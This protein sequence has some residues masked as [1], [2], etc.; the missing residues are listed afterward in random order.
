[1]PVTAV[2]LE[3]TPLEAENGAALRKAGVDLHIGSFAEER[4]MRPA[5]EGADTVHHI[6]AAMREAN[7]PDSH[8]YEINCEATKRL[9][10]WSHE[11]GVRRF[12]YCSTSGV[13][14][15]SHGRVTDE[16][17]ECRPKDIY[18]KSKWAAEQAVFAFGQETGMEVTA[19]RPAAAY[20]AGDGRLLKL[21]RMIQKGRFPLVG[22]GRGKHHL[23]YIDDLN[24]AMMMVAERQEAVGRVYNVAGAESV[25]LVDLVQILAEELGT[26]CTLQ[27]IPMPAMQLLATV[28][29]FSCR[30]FGIQPPLYRRRLDFYRHDEHFSIERAETELGFEPRISL[31][32]G[33]RLTI[34]GYRKQ[35]WL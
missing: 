16:N 20:G 35:G 31:R 33:I 1:M 22:D 10:A 34:E 4:I 6:A 18:Q 23:V 3:A 14:G 8:F 28:I 24:D 13:I 11:A 26:S 7:V 2:S 29:E 15:H 9:L 19:V 12:V 27:R 21:F 30:P 5:L 32:A 17:T 25:P